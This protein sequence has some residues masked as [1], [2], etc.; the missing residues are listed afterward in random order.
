MHQRDDGAADVAAAVVVA[1]A[2]TDV[3][4]SHVVVILFDCF[5][6]ICFD[7]LL[8]GKRVAPTSNGSIPFVVL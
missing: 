6:A 7:L 5:V 1:D 2:R 8:R 3:L 4:L